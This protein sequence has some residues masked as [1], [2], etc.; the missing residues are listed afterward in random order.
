MGNAVSAKKR[1][2]EH[3]ERKLNSR[4]DE[5]SD[6]RKH[7]VRRAREHRSAHTNGLASGGLTA[8]QPQN[9]RD[10]LELSVIVKEAFGVDPTHVGVLYVLDGCGRRRCQTAAAAT[11]GRGGLDGRQLSLS[12]PPAATRTGGTTCRRC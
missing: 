7:L 6:E 9:I 4:H 8:I 5:G 10:V 12:A 11:A 2:V 1:L 3:F